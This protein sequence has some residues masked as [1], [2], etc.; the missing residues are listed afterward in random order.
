MPVL[1]PRQARAASIC[2]VALVMAVLSTGCGSGAD[3]EAEAEAEAEAAPAVD[4]AAERLAGRYAHYDVVAYE[5]TDMKTHIV[6]FGFTDLDVVD[7]ELQATESFCHAD[8]RSDQPIEVEMPDAAT[9]AI[10]PESTPV[11]LTTVDGRAHISRPATPTGIGVDLEDPAND[12]LPTDPDDP[13]IADD[14]NDGNPG[15][16]TRIRVTEDVQG[17]L[18]IAR[19]E[20]FAYDVDEQA[21]GSLTGVVTDNSEQLIIGATNDAFLTQAE[22]V[23]HPDLSK[24]PIILIPVEQDWDCERLMAERDDLFPPT[25]EVDW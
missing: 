20:I 16:T 4:P 15:V 19:R 9:Q 12:P 11:T 1:G 23:Q 10:I 5:S 17:E 2:G 3:G 22:W 24:S 13:R 7:G 21:D 6:S 25:P 8:H 14:D 18:Y